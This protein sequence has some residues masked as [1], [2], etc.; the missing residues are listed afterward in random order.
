MELLVVKSGD[1]YFRFRENDFERCSMNK[2]S[3]YPLHELDKVRSL[4]QM[5]RESEVHAEI[6]KLTIVE[7][8]YPG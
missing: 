4:C 3:V 5:L 1:D 2:A 6:K 7:E 8:D